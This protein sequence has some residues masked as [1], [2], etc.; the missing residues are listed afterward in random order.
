MFKRAFMDSVL[1]FLVDSEIIKQFN[2]FDFA[3]II[4]CVMSAV[5]AYING[6][7]KEILSIIKWWVPTIVAYFYPFRA[8]SRFFKRYCESVNVQIFIGCLAT[9]LISFFC[10][11]IILREIHDRIVD[12]QDSMFS[13]N[14]VLGAIYGVFRV[15]IIV[16][17]LLSMFQEYTSNLKILSTSYSVPHLFKDNKIKASIDSGLERTKKVKRTTKSALTDDDELY[18]ELTHG[19]DE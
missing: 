8:V 12:K 2:A 10:C 18:E 11:Y 17:V 1:D 16:F 19:S 9:F 5:F 14:K 7:V 6:I 4:L 15:L 3:L 13:I